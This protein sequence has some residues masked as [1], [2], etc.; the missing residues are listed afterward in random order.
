MSMDVPWCSSPRMSE[1]DESFQGCRHRQR[2][3]HALSL[4]YVLS[5]LFVK[6]LFVNPNLHRFC[7]HWLT[8]S[9]GQL[10]YMIIDV[11]S[12][13]QRESDTVFSCL[14]LGLNFVGASFGTGSS[15]P[16]TW[17]TGGMQCVP[18]R[19]WPKSTRQR[20]VTSA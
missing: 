6:G 3:G 1:R 11:I 13:G 19:L 8:S 4:K 17:R 10:L 7:S 9:I 14:I 12:E 18:L 2:L 16:H 20:W 15:L 5:Q